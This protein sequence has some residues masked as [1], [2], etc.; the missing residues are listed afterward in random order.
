MDISLVCEYE[1]T[2]PNVH[3]FMRDYILHVRGIYLSIYLQ[4]VAWAPTEKRSS[5]REKRARVSNKCARE[6]H[7]ANKKCVC[8][9]TIR[10]ESTTHGNGKMANDATLQIRDTAKKR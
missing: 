2:T 5:A 8:T 9:A 1:T 3:V 7:L 6:S 10:S 4:V